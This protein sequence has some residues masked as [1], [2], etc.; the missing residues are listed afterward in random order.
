[1]PAIDP[2]PLYLQASIGQALT[3]ELEFFPG[4][5]MTWQAPAAPAGCSLI[6]ADSQAAGAGVGGAAL[7][8]F[9]LSCAQAGKRRL[10]FELKRP[11]EAEV[12]AV[13]PVIVNIT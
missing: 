7:Q 5:G 13:Q 4:A 9:V 8:R 6:A 12:R 2:A 10:R 11:W 3:I 1:M